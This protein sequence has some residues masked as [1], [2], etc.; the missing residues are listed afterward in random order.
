MREGVRV[1]YECGTLPVRI[2]Q[3]VKPL[4][5]QMIQIQILIFPAMLKE[6]NM[7]VYM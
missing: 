3:S 5:S 4:Q 7:T 2:V 6:K 1:V